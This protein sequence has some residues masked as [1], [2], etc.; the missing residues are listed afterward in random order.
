MSVDVKV[1]L[2][3]LSLNKVLNLYLSSY[4]HQFDKFYNTQLI[5]CLLKLD[6]SNCEVDKS[7]LALNIVALVSAVLPAAKG[8]TITVNR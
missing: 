4:F 7:M 8:L 1:K 6:E 3:R 2:A 5:I